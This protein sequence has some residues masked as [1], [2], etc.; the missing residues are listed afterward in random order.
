MFYYAKFYLQMFVVTEENSAIVN[1]DLNLIGNWMQMHL[2][3]ANLVLIPHQ[4]H[5]AE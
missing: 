3:I 4:T 5:P 1:A 2:T